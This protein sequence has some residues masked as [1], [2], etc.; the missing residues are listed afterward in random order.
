VTANFPLARRAARFAPLLLLIAALALRLHHLG[1][2]E[3]NVDQAYPIGQAL[4]TLDRGD[5]PLLGQRTS[6]QI[7]NPPLAGYLYLPIVALTRSAL[8]VQIVVILLNSAGVL[9][10]WAA[11]RAAAGARAAWIAGWLLAVNPWLIEYSRTTWVQALLPFYV[12]ALA[13]LLWPLL[14]GRSRH[15]GA[16]WIAACV[17][18]A[19]AAG[20]YLLAYALLIPIGLWLLLYRQRLAVVPRR[21]LIIGLLIPLISGMVY[22]GALLSAPDGRSGL[23]TF[24]GSGVRFSAEAWD[25]ALRLISGRDYPAARGAEAPTQDGALR[26]TLTDGAHVVISAITLIGI[27][28]ALWRSRRDRRALL[29][30]IGFVAPVAIMTVT[31]QVVHPFYQ[32]LGMPSG[33]ALAGSGVVWLLDRGPRA[34]RWAAAIAAAGLLFAFGALMAISSVRFAEATAATPGAH[35]LGALPLSVGLRLGAALDAALPEDGAVYADVDE[36][37]LASFSGRTFASFW[38]EIDPVRL[39]ILPRAG[40]AYIRIDAAGLTPIPGAQTTILDLADGTAVRLDALAPD[41]ALP[42][43]FDPLEAVGLLDGRAA[44]ALRGW[45]LTQAGDRIA[46][47]L[48]WQVIEADERTAGRLFAPFAHLFTA[49]GERAAIIDAAPVPGYV[50]RT[51]DLHLHRLTFVPPPDLAAIRVGQ[52]DGGAGINLL[53]DGSPVVDL[54][55]D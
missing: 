17:I 24:T 7:P 25:H 40:G 9:L 22:V 55:L 20:S 36:W 3:H 52:Y 37:T 15:P 14:I 28:I 10:G 41:P 46:L 8:A 31:T 42:T 29:L 5:L 39:I 38:R 6:A 54:P 19:L 33:A 47:H 18:F 30:P 49:S 12:P 1:Q 26:Q 50:W 2:I 27:G 35:G 44:L 45:S 53:F 23:E 43:D 34:W 32:L 16:R 21:S 11:I 48:A 13:W 51:G 4:R